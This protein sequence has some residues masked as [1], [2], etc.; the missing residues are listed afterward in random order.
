[1]HFPSS[2][3]W[4]RRK[5]LPRVGGGDDDGAG[6]DLIRTNPIQSASKYFM[7]KN[8]L[9]IHLPAQIQIRIKLI[10]QIKMQQSS[11]R[12]RLELWTSHNAQ[13]I[14]IKIASTA[15]VADHC[16]TVPVSILH[17]ASRHG[18]GAYKPAISMP[19]LVSF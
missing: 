12:A 18:R 4:M 16:A 2:T 17:L 8:Y 13:K 3:L 9:E 11:H 15:H 6:I 1:M 10:I 14:K 7:P 5:V 19:P